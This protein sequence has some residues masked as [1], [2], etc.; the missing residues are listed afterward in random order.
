MTNPRILRNG[1]L[2]AAA[3]AVFAVG[4]SG[5]SGSG[6][7]YGSDDAEAPAT[8]SVAGVPYSTQYFS[9]TLDLALP[10]F[11][12]PAPVEESANFVTWGSPD[13]SVAV[14]ILRPVVLYPPGSTENAPLR[15]LPLSACCWGYLSACPSR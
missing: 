14:R 15:R 13:G 6:D 2:L 9:T 3:L 1:M 10:S 8:T 4:C 5:D 11:V 12:D 7:A